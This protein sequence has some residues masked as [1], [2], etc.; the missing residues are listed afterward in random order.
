[1]K[2]LRVGLTVCFIIFTIGSAGADE[3]YLD[4]A[5]FIAAVDDP[6]F[7]DFEDQSVGPVVGD[8]WLGLGIVFDEAGVGDN[9]AIGDGDG[10]DMNIYALGGQD[11]DI[12]VS[13]P[14]QGA[15]ACGI[16]VFSNDVQIPGERLVFFGEGDVVLADVEMPLAP[17]GTSEFVGYVAD[18]AIV[19][20]A[21]IEGDGDGD[22]VGMGEVVFK[23]R[24]LNP[25]APITWSRIKRLYS[26]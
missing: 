21:F 25:V 22:Y 23:Q 3:V 17:G 7:I 5:G 16:A 6:T 12:D 15:S 10:N 18:V 13:F 20:V 4:R 24:Q 8:P 14:A 9:M 19:R 2:C 11:A 1:M 26:D